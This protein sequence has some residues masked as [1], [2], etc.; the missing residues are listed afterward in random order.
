[1]ARAGAE[2]VAVVEATI[3][4]SV[5]SRSFVVGL[6]CQ[7]AGTNGCQP[8]IQQVTLTLGGPS[9]VLRGLVAADLTPFVDVSL[10]G[11]GTYTMTPVVP[12][13]PNG[14]EIL[15]LAPNSVT[16]RVVAQALPTPTPAP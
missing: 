11:P 8:S 14:V 16:V 2:P 7:G 1:L 12:A 15:Q 5:G 4:L 13:L 6:V 3:G 9:D 10:L